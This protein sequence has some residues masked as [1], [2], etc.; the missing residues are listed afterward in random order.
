MLQNPVFIGITGSAGKTTTKELLLGMLS[1]QGRV[2]GNYESFNKV[3]EVAKTILSVRPT[4]D[5]CVC[6]LGADKPDSLNESLIMLQP[7]VGIVT[8]IANDHL[9]AFSS[10]DAIA[11][12]KEKLVVSLPS[13]GTAVLNADDELV[14]AMAKNCAARV[15][16]FGISEHADV[17]AE[18]I[19]AV[20]PDRLGFTLVHGA[21]RMEVQTR[22]C[23][24]HWATSVLAAI[25]GGLAA[26]MTLDECAVGIASVAP[27]EGRMQ[28]VTTRDGVTFIRDDF[29]APLWTMDSCFEFMKAA[30]AR[31]KIIVIGEL[32]SVGPRKELKYAKT[33]KLAQEIADVTIFAGPWA[34]GA[35]KARKPGGEDALRVFCHVRDAAEYINSIT[36]EGDLVLLK[37]TNKQDHLLR[38]IMARAGEIACWRDDCKRDSFCNQCLDR[39]KPSGAPA[40]APAMIV[41]DTALQ[42]PQSDLYTVAPSEQVI[43][44]LG[45]PGAEHIGTPHNIGYEVVDHLASSLGLSWDD[46]PEARIARGSSQGRSV[47]LVKIQMAMNLTGT[48]LKRLSEYMAFGP[49]QCILVYD[50]LDIPLGSVRTRLSGSAGGHRGIASILEAFQTDA[51]RRVKVGVGQTEAKLNRVEYVLTAFDAASR[52]AADLA[53]K[54][55]HARVIEML[56]DHPIMR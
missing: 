23:G 10:R 11:Q 2:I 22:L 26:G 46:A 16:T 52:A 1:R 51:F 47:C 29:K 24:S 55:A 18:N 43:I 5:F 27:F 8:L 19:G 3:E 44:G 40:S 7:G 4:H 17:R 28:P 13:T 12:E 39:T 21:E 45:N 54:A 53:I 6:E 20:W 15:M 42:V 37:G 49:E 50:D 14:L 25:G 31:R 32:S 9:G 30:R 48:G 38:I 34:S 41:S 56:A 33:A 36:R 35:L